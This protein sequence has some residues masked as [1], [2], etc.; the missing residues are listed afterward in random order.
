[1]SAKTRTIRGEVYTAVVCKVV[2]RD[3]HGRPRKL[4]TLYDEESTKL[5]GG[6]EFLIGFFKSD[7][8]AK[9]TS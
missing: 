9:R 6:E 5:E 2:G 7:C 1:M 3:A 4:E 8:V